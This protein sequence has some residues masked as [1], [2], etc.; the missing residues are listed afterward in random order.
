M[1]A[2]FRLIDFFWF[3]AEGT[4]AVDASSIDTRSPEVDD[5][6]HIADVAQMPLAERDNLTARFAQGVAEPGANKS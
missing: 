6:P 5:R 1:Y 4:V 2:T 3:I